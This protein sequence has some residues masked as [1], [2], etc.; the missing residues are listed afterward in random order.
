M[1]LSFSACSGNKIV[2]TDYFRVELNKKEKYA[3]VL[4]L[5]DLGKEQEILAIPMFV[6]G[7]PVKQ[8][9]GTPRLN[10]LGIVFELYS[11]NLKKIYVPGSVECIIPGALKIP[12]DGEIIIM[13]IE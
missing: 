13:R 5:T 10:L 12:S 9:G 3:I 7:L 8:V 6:E 1:L 4:E 11:D 2:E